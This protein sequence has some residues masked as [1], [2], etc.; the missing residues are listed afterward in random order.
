[1][2]TLTAKDRRLLQHLQSQA[3]RYFQDNQ[4]PAGLLLDRQRNGSPLRTDGLCSTAATGMGWIALALASAEPYRLF[5]HSEA[6]QRVRT[7]LQTA[8]HQ[9][10]NERGIMPHF[11]DAQTGRVFGTDHLSTVDSA[12][13]T[14]G[15]LWAAAFLGDSEL[16]RLA[17]ALYDRIDWLHWTNPTHS[18]TPLLSHGQTRDGRFLPHSWDRINGETIFMYVLASGADE[19]RA[20]PDSVWDHLRPFYGEM[21]GRRFN[22]SDLG[23]FVFQYGLDLLDLENWLPPSGVD[24]AAEATVATEANYRTCRD[25]ADPFTTYRD[26]WGLSAGDGPGTRPTDSAYRS[27]SPAGP[28]DGTAHLTASVASIAWQPHVVLENLHHAANEHRWNLEGRYGLRS[29]NADRGWISSDMVGID[30]GALI[31]ALDNY[32]FDDRI[33][34]VF[35]SL[36]CVQRGLERSG[37]ISRIR[38]QT[39]AA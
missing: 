26:Y 11:V 39:R 2:A 33:R 20:L 6:V 35:H 4:T 27:Y 18:E 25:L 24:L 8:L 3:L 12:W 21:A 30:A 19:K 34:T 15:A 36:P 1:M 22:N 13:L 5:E 31:L 23:L 9:L 7:G 16:Q 29:L 32:L 14:A 17:T 37:F 28:I 10:P 38:V